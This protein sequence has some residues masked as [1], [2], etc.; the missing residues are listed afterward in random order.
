MAS[1]CQAV[2]MLLTSAGCLF[3]ELQFNWGVRGRDQLTNGGH[4]AYG[5]FRL[6]MAT[7]EVNEKKWRDWVARQGYLDLPSE[8]RILSS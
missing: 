6:V 5:G 1:G 2:R 7:G 4:D 3:A 8:I